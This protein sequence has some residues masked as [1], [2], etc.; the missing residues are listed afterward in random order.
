MLQSSYV[1]VHDLV[2]FRAGEFP[3]NQGTLKNNHVQN[4]KEKSRRE[5]S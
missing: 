4:E 3:W 2:Y 1:Q 5:K